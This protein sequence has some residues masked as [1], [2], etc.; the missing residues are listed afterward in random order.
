MDVPLI[1]LYNSVNQ[2]P[3]GPVSNSAIPST[4][5]SMLLH[6]KILS[7]LINMTE[8]TEK[9]IT[10]ERQKSLIKKEEQIDLIDSHFHF[11]ILPNKP[12]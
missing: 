7:I 2:Y 10:L 3:L 4:H 9:L 6:W 11:D 1:K 8:D 5:Q 12:N